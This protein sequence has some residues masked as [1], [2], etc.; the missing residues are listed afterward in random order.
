MDVRPASKYVLLEWMVSASVNLINLTP[1]FC[2]S[3]LLSALCSQGRGFHPLQP[4]DSF[5]LA[6]ESGR[7]WNLWPGFRTA[8][9]AG[10]SG[11]LAVTSHDVI[12]L[13]TTLIRVS[14]E[15]C[16]DSSLPA[17]LA[18]QRVSKGLDDGFQRDRKAQNKCLKS[19]SLQKC[20]TA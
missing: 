14:E 4:L 10:M 13:G 20:V 12:S 17:Q 11:R 16:T 8:A 1:L 2:R 7:Q 19:V 15:A 9:T 6:G 18:S 5:A 3:R